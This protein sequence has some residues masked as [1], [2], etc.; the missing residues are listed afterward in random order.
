L[1]GESFDRRNSI[2]ALEIED[3]YARLKSPVSLEK[4]NKRKLTENLTK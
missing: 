4:I 2:G 1:V 3:V